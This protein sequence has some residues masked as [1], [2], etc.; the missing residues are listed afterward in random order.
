MKYKRIIIMLCLLIP[1]IT[2]FA[3]A[4]DKAKAYITW[5]GSYESEPLVPQEYSVYFNTT[6]GS[7]Y[8]YDGAEWQL[9]AEQG[10]PG[11]NANTDEIILKIENLQMQIDALS[12]R[13]TELELENSIINLR[14]EQLAPIALT[15]STDFSYLVEDS[16]IANSGEEFAFSVIVKNVLNEPISTL[17]DNDFSLSVGNIISTTYNGDGEYIVCSSILQ[18]GTTTLRITVNGIAINDSVSVELNRVVS[19]EAC[20]FDYSQIN[21]PFE[22]SDFKTADFFAISVNIF[23]NLGNPINDLVLENFYFGD[24][25]NNKLELNNLYNGKYSILMHTNYDI[26]GPENKYY[27]LPVSVLNTNI[28][29]V[30]VREIDLFYPKYE[31]FPV[32]LIDTPVDCVVSCT[33]EPRNQYDQLIMGFTPDDYYVETNGYEFEIFNKG[34]RGFSFVPKQTG[35]YIIDILSTRYDLTKYWSGYFDAY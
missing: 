17:S 20:S 35:S 22:T 9:F 34:N 32:Y 10:P 26:F 23:D 27:E 28:G 30:S 1:L 4:G 25:D 12:Q 18:T 31:P 15:P 29:S 2:I 24:Y 7:S 11:E 21:A 16:I 3:I 6:Q 19:P 5:I 8:I 33:F 13:T 14:L